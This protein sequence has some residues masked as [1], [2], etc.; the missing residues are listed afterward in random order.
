MFCKHLLGVHTSTTTDGVLL[1]LGRIPLH[2]FEKKATIKNWKRIRS[3]KCNSRLST[4]Y[5]SA[6]NESLDWIAK[7]KQFLAE[8]GMFNYFANRDI[9]FV[10]NK[11]YRRLADICF[12]TQISS[13]SRVDSKL[14][15]YSLIKNNT[16]F[17]KYLSLI[18]NGNRRC[19]LTKFRLSNH[20]LMIEVGRNE[21]IPKDQRFCPTYE[22]KVEDEVHFLTE[23]KA[24]N[25]MR[26]NLL[27]YALRC[28]PNLL[29]YNTLDKFRYLMTCHT[30]QDAV[31]KFAHNAMEQRKVK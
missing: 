1:E 20:V 3:S 28:N 23:C 19:S 16:G 25:S 29:N 7:I 5:N 6:V 18:R 9:N 2:V 14:R 8:I 10:H 26:K 12:Q 13:I 4:S 30:L 15:T 11:V 22:N 27:H 31:A 21:K 24:Y 17:E